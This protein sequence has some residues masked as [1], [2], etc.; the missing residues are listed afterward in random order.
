MRGPHGGWTVADRCLS[1]VDPSAQG[2]SNPCRPP[3]LVHLDVML[4]FFCKW[5]ADMNSRL[6]IDS[7]CTYLFPL[8]FFFIHPRF[9]SE[10][11][12]KRGQPGKS[13]YA[14]AELW[15]WIQI[16]LWRRRRAQSQRSPRL[17]PQKMTIQLTQSQAR[18]IESSSGSLMYASCR[19]SLYYGLSR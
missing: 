8:P 6:G 1:T 13:I 12:N 10:H 14:V 11:R 18:S 3:P 17:P 19:L 2:P 9:L 15:N 4:Q 7:S 5:V 16:S